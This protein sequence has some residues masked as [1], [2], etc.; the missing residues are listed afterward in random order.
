[1][2]K[3]GSGKVQTAW[4]LKI[5]YF[6]T[7]TVYS[8]NCVT[9]LKIRSVFQ[10]K[11]I[12]VQWQSIQQGV[13]LLWNH[14]EQLIVFFQGFVQKRKE[15]ILWTLAFHKKNKCL[16]THCRTVSH[17]KTA[18]SLLPYREVRVAQWLVFCIVFCR[19][20]FLLLSFFIWPLY[21]Q[22]IFHSRFWVPL[23]LH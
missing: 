23:C 10:F 5:I 9:H 14:H 15:I 12:I 1:M 17:L 7:N 8:K 22:I 16:G 4:T 3:D 11:I 13:R 21:C 18:V 6:W 20:L 2:P 19:S